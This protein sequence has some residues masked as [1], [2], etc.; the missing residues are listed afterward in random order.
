MFGEHLIVESVGRGQDAFKSS[1][2]GPDAWVLGDFWQYL[3]AFPV[4]IARA[5]DAAEIC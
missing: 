3:E 2:S 4:A 1:G 5:E